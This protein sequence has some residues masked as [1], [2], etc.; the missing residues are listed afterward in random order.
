MAPT[1]DY[2]VPTATVSLPGLFVDR[3]DDS[4]F[5]YDFRSGSIQPGREE[6]EFAQ[7]WAKRKHIRT[8]KGYRTVFTGTAE[9]LRTLLAAAEAY[10]IAAQQGLE[11]SEAAACGKAA[12]R[13]QKALSELAA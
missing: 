11:P 10:E 7:A 9:D 12:Q 2:I 8:G 3:F 4:Q 6:Y 1:T 5:S 13:L